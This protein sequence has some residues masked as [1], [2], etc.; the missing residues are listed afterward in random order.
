MLENLS[1]I[2]DYR[3]G[4]EGRDIVEGGAVQVW[5]IDAHAV[6]PHV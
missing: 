5:V 6:L 4:D 2:S 1:C 3:I